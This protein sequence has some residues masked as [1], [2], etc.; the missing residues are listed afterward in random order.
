MTLTLFL[1]RLFVLPSKFGF[2]KFSTTYKYLN[3]KTLE[4]LSLIIN[5]LNKHF[6]L[7][8]SFS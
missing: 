7:N 5:N 1:N 2:Y 3:L 8:S 4:V 6:S